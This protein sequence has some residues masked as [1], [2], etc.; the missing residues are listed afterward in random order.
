M[1]RLEFVTASIN[2]DTLKNNLLLS[3]AFRFEGY[4]LTVQ[5]G[6]TNIAKAYNEAVTKSELVCYLHDDVYLSTF[7]IDHLEYSLSQLPPD[8]EVLGVAGVTGPPKQIHGYI[9]DRGKE[10]G[11]PLEKPVKVDTLDELLLITRGNIKFDEQFEQDF[12]GAD[13][14]IGRNAYVIPAFVN[15]NSSRPFGGRTEKFYEAERLFRNKHLNK[16]PIVTTCTTITL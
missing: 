1:R 6:Y 8:W 7:F 10:W 14:C 9:M 13:I 16:L 15:H 3:E 5:Q 11:E 4:G 2:P 12:Y